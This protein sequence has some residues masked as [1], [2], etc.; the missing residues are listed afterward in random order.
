M[1]TSFVHLMPF[2]HSSSSQ[3]LESLELLASLVLVKPR[4]QARASLTRGR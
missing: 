2:E 1:A 3:D 4:E